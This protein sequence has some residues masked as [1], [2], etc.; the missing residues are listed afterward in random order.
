M[1]NLTKKTIT[2]GAVVALALS[3]GAATTANAAVT[4]TAGADR[5]STATEIF[6]AWPTTTDTA[7]L[8]AG[9]GHDVD[10]LTVAP[11]AKAKNAPVILVDAT[12][13]TASIVAQFSAFKNVYIANGTGVISADVET[14]LTAAGKTVTRL[15]GATRTETALNIAKK[16]GASNG[17]VVANGDNAHLVDTLSVASIA[18]AKGMPIFLTAGGSLSADEV[19]YAKGLG[20]TNVY[21][22]G[23]TSVVSDAAVAGLGT[24]TRLAG[25]GRYETNA[26]V[27]NAFKADLDLTNIYVASGEDANLIDALA[28]APLAGLKNAPIVFAHDT[29]NADVNTLLNSVVTG[30]T[31]IKILGGTGAVTAAA[32]TALNAVQA[33]K[34]TTLV[35]NSANAINLKQIK[36][37]FSRGVD[38][39]SAQDYTKYTLNGTKLTAA[40]KLELQSDNMTVLVTLNTALPNNTAYGLVVDQVLGTNAALSAVYSTSVSYADTTVPSIASASVTASNTVRVVFN[41]PVWDGS[42]LNLTPTD[43]VIDGGSYV[44]TSATAVPNASAVDLVLGSAI[45]SG[46]HSVK[47]ISG[48]SVKD[49]AGYAPMTQT[50]AFNFTADTSAPTAIVESATETTVTLK[51]SKPVTSASISNGNIRFRHTYDTSA[52]EVFGN[53]NVTSVNGTDPDTEWKVDFTAAHPMAPG[54]DKIYIEYV[55]TSGTLIQDTFGNTFA[56]TTLSVPVVVDT[57]APTI[58]SISVYDSNNVDV[59]FSEGVTGAASISNYVL[60]DASANTIAINNI[61]NTTGNTYRLNTAALTGG[62]YNLTVG[63]VQDKSLAQNTMTTVT[64]AFSASDATAPTV[65]SVSLSNDKTKLRVIFSEAMADAGL[66]TVSNYKLSIDAAAGV[67]LPTGSTITRVD[68]KTIDI[69]LVG[70]V[71]NL[72]GTTDSLLLSGAMTDLAGNSVGGFSATA[73]ITVDT[74]ALVA[75]SMKATDKRTIQFRVNKQVASVD[76]SKFS[77]T[78]YAIASVTAANDVANNQGIITVKLTTDLTTDLSGVFSVTVGNGGI[79]TSLGYSGSTIGSGVTNVTT[80]DYIAPAISTVTTA[81]TDADGQIDHVLITY[82]ENIQQS[83]VATGDYTVSGHTVSDYAVAGKV[84][85]LTISESGTNDTNA[86][87]DVTQIGAIADNSAQHNVLSSNALITSTDAAQAYVTGNFTNASAKVVVV[88]FSEAMDPATL[89]AANFSSVAGGA[90]TLVK[91]ADNKSVTLTFTNNLATSDTVVVTTSVKDA[92]GVAIASTTLTK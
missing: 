85:T 61:T 42:D 50:L 44:V 81:D 77:I 33:T 39:T 4:R 10:A 71:T 84:V 60:K 49:Y 64:K 37:V 55:N 23:G 89:I 41:E 82:T 2:R 31:N 13:S 66:T 20:A 86:T 52:T 62:T 88:N 22:L 16:L 65:S 68:S 38:K 91:A 90:L 17:I 69:N 34:N 35:V 75:D 80:A 56:A 48:N 63:G 12:A 24:A 74:T 25:S 6:K 15:G 70:L 11:L 92:N 1:G 40:D 79:T 76:A 19:T 59:T 73:P 47:I 8:A 46:S 78:N 30:T 28:G 7:V 36:V 9:M 43:F 14:A 45:S 54:T 18:A 21:A 83:S 72:D 87:P 26:A 57:V 32:E 53:A 51:F 27:I 5:Y 3:A 29:V 58:S 67:S